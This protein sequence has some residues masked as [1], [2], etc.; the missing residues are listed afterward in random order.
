MRIVN[1]STQMMR[2]GIT[3]CTLKEQQTMQLRL[4]KAERTRLD[5]WMAAEYY[6]QP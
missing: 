3:G 6:P 5:P 4:R 2:L 1:L